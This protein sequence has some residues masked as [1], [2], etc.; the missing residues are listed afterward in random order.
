MKR[1]LQ[2]KIYI[3]I[4]TAMLYS[5]SANAQIV[6]TDINPDVSSN[7]A[8]DVLYCDHNNLTTLDFST[9][10]TFLDCE[11]NQLTSLGVETK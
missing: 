6:Y 9:N 7:P 3:F 10:L 1:Q 5:L 2:K 4:G 8:I 11:Y